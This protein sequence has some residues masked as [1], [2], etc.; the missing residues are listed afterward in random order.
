MV[1]DY[2]FSRLCYLVSSK[3]SLLSLGAK[4]ANMPTENNAKKPLKPSAVVEFEFDANT[5]DTCDTANIQTPSKGE[6]FL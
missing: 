4:N 2:P 5:R 1:K 3:E 6:V